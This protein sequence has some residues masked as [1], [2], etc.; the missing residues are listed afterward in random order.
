MLFPARAILAIDMSP[1]GSSLGLLP[2]VRALR[3]AYPDALLVGATATGTCELLA[4]AGLLDDKIDLGVIKLSDHEYRG[5]LRR[6]AGLIRQARHYSFDLVLDFSP[7]LET[8]LAA[9]LILRARTFTPSRIP[10]T[11]ELVLDF[12]GIPRK[13]SS[14]V[15]KYKTVV[16]QAGVQIDDPSLRLAVP[17]DANAR[18]EQRLLKGGSRGGE[19]LVLL[20][21]SDSNSARTWPVERFAEM[22][23]RMSNNFAARAIAADEPSDRA[24]TEALSTLLPPGAIKL[25]E[26]RALELLA[27]IARASLTITDEP[28]I[29]RIASE[30]RTPVVEI[31]DTA[32]RSVSTS[33]THRI[34]KGS[35]RKQV[36][37]QEV[38]EA[39]CGLIQESRSPI[40]FQRP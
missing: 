21:G 40:L 25:A 3:S 28:A 24:F 31:A 1:F 5:A 13:S 18:F 36:T 39:A 33:S 32:S 34:L 14:D 38:Y 8:Q 9:H 22:G 27:A 23:R 6:L 17:E 35:S 37:T 2:A 7:R 29:A 4:A 12:A 20:Y 30:L 16:E 10:R 26:P 15:S 11:I 19:L